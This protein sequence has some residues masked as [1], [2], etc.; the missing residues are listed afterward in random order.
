MREPSVGSELEKRTVFAA[1]VPFKS[2][3]ANSPRCVPI[4]RVPS[5]SSTTE[6]L[7]L[8]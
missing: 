7:A 5:C 4:R 6:W 1:T 8:P 3:A 2:P